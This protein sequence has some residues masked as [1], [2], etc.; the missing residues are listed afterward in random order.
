MFCR[1]Q[2]EEDFY[3]K[4]ANNPFSELRSYIMN[5]GDV[6]GNEFYEQNINNWIEEEILSLHDIVQ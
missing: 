1:L 6:L 4:S 5:D 2:K 3:N